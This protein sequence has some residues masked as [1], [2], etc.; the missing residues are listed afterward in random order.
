M[1]K[2]AQVPVPKQIKP[3]GGGGLF[4]TAADYVRFLQM[5]LRGGQGILKPATID[6]MRRNQIGALNVRRMIS[7]QPAFSRDFGFHIEA[8]DKFGFGF[9]INPVAYPNGRAANSMA[10]AGLWN[11]FFWIDPESGLCAV[12]L[13]QSS[14]FFDEPAIRTLQAFEA[15]VYQDKH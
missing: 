2:E 8:G 3:H 4:S 1:Y 7:N 10:W 12:I 14:P 11:T 15:A 5:F 6:A 13:M 9:Q